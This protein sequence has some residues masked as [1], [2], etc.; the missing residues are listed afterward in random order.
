MAFSPAARRAAA[1]Y[2]RTHHRQQGRRGARAAAVRR[3]SD[4]YRQER[5]HEREHASRSTNP[6]EQRRAGVTRTDRVAARAGQLARLAEGG[7]DR[8]NRFRR[9]PFG[10]PPSSGRRRPAPAPAGR[11]DAPPSGGRR[12]PPA[13]SGGQR[14]SPEQQFHDRLTTAAGRRQAERDGLVRRTEDG[15]IEPT[16]R[17]RQAM[18]GFTPPGGPSGGGQPP[19]GRRRATPAGGS[20]RSPS[21][22]TPPAG[23]SR[24]R[25]PEQ[26]FQARLSTEAGRQRAER[27]G[28]I[29]RT[30]DGG[31]EPTERGRQAMRG[32]TPPPAGGQRRPPPRRRPPAAGSSGN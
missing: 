17:G 5:E 12:Q 14:R 24:S 19:A 23:G 32:W 20:G 10:P 25:S 8:V 9:E 15:G 31:Y 4:A 30:E 27:D 21:R 11:R 18:N 28:L 3:A 6:R 22:R 2:W 16:E 1:E 26:R 13:P 7:S 29:R